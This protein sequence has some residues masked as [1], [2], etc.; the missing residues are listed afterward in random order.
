[1]SGPLRFR[2]AA[3]VAIRK[4]S[5]W[6]G[7][8]EA[9]ISTSPTV[10][11]GSGAPSATE[12]NGS[13]YLRTNGSSASTLYVRVS[14][15][16]VPTSPATFLSAEITGDGSAQSTAHGLATVPTLV[17]AIPSDI[18]GGAFAVTYGTHTTTNAIATVTTGEKYRIVA[19]K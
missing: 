9:L 11:S 14:S 8:T 6:T 4:L 13:V 2:D 12:P 7:A 3:G 17:F 19:F 10:T 5:V 16:W 15:A 18:T 1:M